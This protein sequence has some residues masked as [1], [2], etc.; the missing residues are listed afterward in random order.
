MS[1]RPISSLDA[2]Y[3]VTH[4]RRAPRH[5]RTTTINSSL[6]AR[7]IFR[8]RTRADILKG[9]ETPKNQKAQGHRSQRQPRAIQQ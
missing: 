9:N 1:E 8:G 6:P 2:D 5:D 7:P 4:H 3:S